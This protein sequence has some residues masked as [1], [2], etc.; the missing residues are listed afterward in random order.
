MTHEAHNS[1][2]IA[3]RSLMHPYQG[4]GWQPGVQSSII[5]VLPTHLAQ[6]LNVGTVPIPFNMA[7]LLSCVTTLK[8]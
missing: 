2:L 1:K 6:K 8:E 4:T 7:Y 3:V 5:L